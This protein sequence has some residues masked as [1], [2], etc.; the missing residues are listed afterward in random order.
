[1][2]AGDKKIDDILA[3]SPVIP[4]LSIADLEQAVSLVGALRSG[5]LR[6]IEIT[7]RTACALDAI[8]LIAD[9]LK[10]VV[11]GAGTAITP[12]D[13]ASAESAGA[14]FAVSPGATDALLRSAAQSS[15]PFLPGIATASEIIAAQEQ[16][17]STVKFFPAAA[18]GGIAMLK[19]FAGPFPSVKFCPTGGVREDNFRDY[20]KLENVIAVGGTWLAPSDR[21]KSA[22]WEMIRLLAERASKSTAD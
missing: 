9:T 15:L 1:M 5:G 21:V 22:D 19:A 14:Q 3:L 20:L 6:V 12:E 17:F 8:R 4:V 13:L 2:A 7:L 18:A 11:V 10:D 16:G